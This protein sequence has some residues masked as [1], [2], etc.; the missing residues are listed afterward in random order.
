MVRDE[1]IDFGTIN[2]ENFVNLTQI[3]E[4]VRH[5]QNRVIGIKVKRGTATMEVSLTPKTW[6]GRGLLGCNVV[7]IKQI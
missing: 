2:A 7:P 5:S 1:I 4:L 3:G 6:S